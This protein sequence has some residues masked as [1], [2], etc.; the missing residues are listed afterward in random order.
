[1]F[2]EMFSPPDRLGRAG[3]ARWLAWT[4]RS[5]RWRPTSTT[6]LVI[7][8]RNYRLSEP[9]RRVLDMDADPPA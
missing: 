9:Y 2:A 8:L 1:M 7:Y 6:R 3:V 5:W 4:G